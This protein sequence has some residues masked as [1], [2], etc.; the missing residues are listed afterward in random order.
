MELLEIEK[1]VEYRKKLFILL[2]FKLLILEEWILEL[3][4]ESIEFDKLFL[5][6]FIKKFFPFFNFLFFLYFLFLAVYVDFIELFKEFEINNF[7]FL[8][9]VLLLFELKEES[10]L[11]FFKFTTFDSNNFFILF[12]LFKW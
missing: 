1:D 5:W 10:L 7:L 6:L 8:L 3:F 11:I 2:L 4:M 9:K 12:C